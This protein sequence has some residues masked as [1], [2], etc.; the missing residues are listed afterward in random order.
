MSCSEFL[1]RF[2]FGPSVICR[3]F[4]EGPAGF[5]SN[6]SRLWGVPV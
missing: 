4:M 6:L 2:C 5:A 1:L 3:F